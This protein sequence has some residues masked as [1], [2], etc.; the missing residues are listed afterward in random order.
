MNQP[1]RL[2]F[3]SESSV[4]RSSVTH[5]IHVHSCAPRLTRFFSLVFL[6]CLSLS[7][8]EASSPRVSSPPD[9][10]FEKVRERDRDPA[11]QFYKKYLEVGGLPVL[12]SAEVADEALERT[13]YIVTHMLAGRP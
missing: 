8:A 5:G 1:P 4:F 7:L 6:T 9:S 2:H 13:S 3:G 12:A 11:R 10:F